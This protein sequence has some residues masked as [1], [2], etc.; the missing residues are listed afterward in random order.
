MMDYSEALIKARKS[1][2]A[3]E[4]MVINKQDLGA[5]IDEV[6]DA[7]LFVT[8]MWSAL[9]RLRDEKLRDALRKPA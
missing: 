8:T 7:L 9:R 3:A 5:A 1:L 6:R 4:D 2:T